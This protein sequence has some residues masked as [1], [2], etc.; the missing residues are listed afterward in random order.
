[1]FAIAYPVIQAVSAISVSALSKTYGSVEGGD[2]LY[3]EG[4][5]FIANEDDAIVKLQSGT[6]HNIALTKTGEVFSWGG[7]SSG[8]LGTGDTSTHI[9]PYDITM[10]FNGETIDTVASGFAHTVAVS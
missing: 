10:Q 1:M 3:I 2:T 4:D 5:G 6:Y 9:A 8:E 7:N